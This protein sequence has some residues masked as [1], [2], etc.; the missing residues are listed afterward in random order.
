M[1]RPRHHRP[2]AT[3][4]RWAALGLIGLAAQP[5]A[6]ALP[7]LGS[8][9]AFSVLGASTVTNTGASTVWGDLGVSPGLSITGLASV[10]LTGT[11]HAGD[12]VAQ[13]AQADALTA[14][15]GLGALAQSMDLSGVDLAG[16]V[17]TPGVYDFASS[18]QLSGTLV[19]DDQGLVDAMYVFRIGSALTVASGGTVSRINSHGGDAIF[20]QVGSS[21]TL[22]TGSRLAGNVL[23]HTS[24]TLQ[25]D[26]QIACGRAIALNGAVTMDHNTLSTQC[27]DPLGGS[28]VPEPGTPAL[29]ALALAGLWVSRRAGRGISPPGRP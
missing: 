6:Q 1:A 3:P 20:W 21:A 5:A 8:A 19:L 7:L 26:A 18:A 29:L 16:L 13:A 4:W 11:V 15:N 27:P 10:T 23:A 9:Q 17:L 24:I 14:F 12:A 25:T 28:T 22:G 2:A